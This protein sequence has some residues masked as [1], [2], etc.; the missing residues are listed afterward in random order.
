MNKKYLITALVVAG[1][2][3]AGGYGLYRLGITRGSALSA[4]ATSA[5]API[6][7]AKP[8]PVSAPQGI[9]QG[10][11]ATRRH[12]TAGLKAGDTDPV[13]GSKILSSF[14]DRVGKVL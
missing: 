13:T 6:A 5:A 12:I 8:E 11:E 4:P 3:G 7:V 9:A 10:E 1:M 14:F 2:L